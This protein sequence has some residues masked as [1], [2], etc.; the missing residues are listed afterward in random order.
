MANVINIKT[1]FSAHLITPVVRCSYP[2]LWEPN[3][4][5]DKDDITLMI[6]KS[7]KAT[8]K[9]LRDLAEEAAVKMWGADRP[10]D[11][12]IHITDGDDK[13][14]K[15]EEYAGHWLI[16]AKISKKP[17]VLDATGKGEI[18]DAD[19]VYGGCWVRADISA[20]AYDG[21]MGAGVSWQLTKVQKAR[22]G[23]RFSGSGGGGREEFDAIPV[24]VGEDW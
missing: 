8:Y 22:D 19:E 23:D 16:L 11:V 18:F 14:E 17:K 3:S 12:E 9:A 4:M 1:A 7:D 6:P 10:K 5:S 15:N 13:I 20:K 2:H 24:A 21:K